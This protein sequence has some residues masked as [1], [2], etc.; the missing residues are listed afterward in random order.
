MFSSYEKLLIWRYLV[1]GAEGRIIVLVAGIG[2]TAVTIGVAALIVVMSVMNGA[3]TELAIQFAGVDGHASLSRP[4]EYLDDWR[5]L[6][7]EARRQSGVVS[8]VP[9]LDAAVMASVEGRV[10]PANVRGLR[11]KDMRADPMFEASD[12]RFLGTLPTSEGQVIVG[13]DLAVALGI[14]IGSPITILRP[15]FGADQNL[16]LESVGYTVTALVTTGIPQHDR[17][18]VVMDMHA[19]QQMLESGDVASR[20]N[21]TTSDADRV[22]E[23]LAPLKAGLE[24]RAVL[25]TWRELNKAVFDALALDQIGMFIAVSIIVVVA[26]FNILSSLMMLVASK[27]RDIAIMRTMGASRSAILRIFVAVGTAIGSSGALLGS[28]IGLSLVAAKEDIATFLKAHVLQ[29]S[30]GQELSVIIDLPA[31]IS[32]AETAGILLM[33]LT[34]TILATLYPALKAANV[35]PAYALRYE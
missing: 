32:V 30:Y 20:I 14:S 23:Q 31:E 11:S 27:V 2:L 7:A 4:G 6:E 24:G 9:A 5:E 13:T 1:P 21:L 15:S 17:T 22:A 35:D 34:G 16:S 19:A 10:L 12:G 26:Q 28:V 8:S 25:Q 18:L 33:T 29:G 3:R